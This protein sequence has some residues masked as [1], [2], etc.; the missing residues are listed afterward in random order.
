M[1]DRLAMFVFET[2]TQGSRELKKK[3]NHN[4]NYDN[5]VFLNSFKWFRLFFHL[6]FQNN[7]ETT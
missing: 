5:S 6:L 1:T 2:Y 4:K 3:K 7:M